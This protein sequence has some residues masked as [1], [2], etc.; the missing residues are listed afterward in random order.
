M[1][2]KNNT[3]NN[4]TQF[5][6]YIQQIRITDRTANKYMNNSYLSVMTTNSTEQV[7]LIQF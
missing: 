6:N 4:V 2:L 3:E 5:K 1:V 7:N